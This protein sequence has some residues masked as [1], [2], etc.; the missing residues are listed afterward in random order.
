[1]AKITLFYIEI[2]IY[3][4]KIVLLDEPTSG[5]DPKGKN[6]VFRLIQEEKAGK[7]IILITHNVEEAESIADRIA[8]I[9]QGRLK[10]FGSQ[11]FLKN[12]IGE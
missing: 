5:V 4:I 10:C 8:I 12:H 3:V 6:L 9:D 2:H 11:N 1:L 7:S